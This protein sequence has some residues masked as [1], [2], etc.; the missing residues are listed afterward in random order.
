MSGTAKVQTVSHEKGNRYNISVKKQSRKGG[1]KSKAGKSSE[2]AL[3]ADGA[4]TT[5]P[6]LLVVAGEVVGIPSCAVEMNAIVDSAE[7]TTATA[8][9]G[10]SSANSPNIGES[11]TIKVTCPPDV[12]AGQ[13]I[14]V[15]T[16]NYGVVH[17]TVP[18]HAQAGTEFHV[19]VPL[20]VVD[21]DLSS[22]Y[23][24]M[25]SVT[26]RIISTPTV[27]MTVGMDYESRAAVSGGG[28]A[29]SYDDGLL[30]D[31]YN[32]L[33]PAQMGP[34][35]PVGAIFE[36]LCRKIDELNTK[37]ARMDMQMKDTKNQ[38]LDLQGTVQT[39]TYNV[40]GFDSDEH[41]DSGQEPE[42]AQSASTSPISAF[43]QTKSPVQN[44]KAQGTKA[45]SQLPKLI[46]S[47]PAETANQA[48][49]VGSS[50]SAGIQSMSAANADQASPEVQA[51]T[52]E[53]SEHGRCHR[54]YSL[55]TL[56]LVHR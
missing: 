8:Q 47:K 24:A 14:A 51:P 36:S 53:A 34:S 13:V 23:A 7:T 56:V 21:A 44:V 9:S 2:A 50:V 15:Q 31:H 27:N 20:S 41:E 6:A 11:L 28:S 43:M 42:V 19:E 33:F 22:G 54:E 29:V 45:G 12:T 26:P 40:Q 32:R 5:S 55:C 1:T 38:V 46:V 16:S 37:V 4:S 10:S 30:A 17:V 25:A 18:E 49:S 35:Q 52:V 48:L 3:K 39:I